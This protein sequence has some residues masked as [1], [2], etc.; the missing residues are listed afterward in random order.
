MNITLRLLPWPTDLDNDGSKKY[1]SEDHLI[2]QKDNK[3]IWAG[4]HIDVNLNTFLK[5]MV[6]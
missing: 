2:L 6:S 5:N 1:V 3:Q 4:M